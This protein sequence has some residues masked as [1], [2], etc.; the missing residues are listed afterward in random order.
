MAHKLGLIGYG[1]MAEWHHKSINESV[2]GLEVIATF[3]IRQERLD[4]AEKNGLIP[5]KT[6]EDVLK[7]ALVSIDASSILEET[8][9]HISNTETISKSTAIYRK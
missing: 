3:D 5:C 4:L 8:L 2:D 1:G 9:P 7:N 6:L